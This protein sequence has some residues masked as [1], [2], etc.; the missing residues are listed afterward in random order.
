MSLHYM[1]HGF[2]ETREY[3]DGRTKQSFRD[4]TNINKILARAQKTG[5]LSHMSKFQ[6]E[7]ADY[8]DFD[9]LEAQ[10][11]L[12]RGTEIFEQLP[13]EVKREFGQQPQAF[14]EFVNNVDN[15]DDLKRVL[16]QL[17]E[18]DRYFPNPG[19]NSTE[20][21]VDPEPPK[22]DTPPDA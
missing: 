16:P 19:S 6:G 21:Q 7:Y 3:K 14:F 8:S 13:S 17:A 5:T 9:F 22:E 10:I 20:P 4:Q 11:K 18:L 2:I 15:R 1:K 12:A